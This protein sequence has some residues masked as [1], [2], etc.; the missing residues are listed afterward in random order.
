[1]PR[2]FLVKKPSVSPGK[3]NWSE[4]PDHE[5]GDI[6][7]PV[8][9]VF[10]LCT[11]ESEASPAES[12]PNFSQHHEHS[13]QTHIPARDPHVYVHMH[14]HTAELP[15]STAQG[16]EQSPN[17]EEQ[18]RTK[19]ST[20][21]RSKIK[22]TTGELPGNVSASSAPAAPGM[23]A[24]VCQVCQKTFQFQ[25]ML[26]RHLKC[27]NETK[28]HPCHFCGKGFN[29]TFDLK[30]H[31]RTHTGVR[32]Y[33]CGL[34][35][36]AFTQR[37]S[38]ESHMKKIHGVMQQY[39]YKERRSKLYVCEECGH[40]APTQETLLRHLHTQ[41][42]NSALLRSKGRKLTGAAAF[43]S[44]DRESL[45]SGSPHSQNC[46]DKCGGMPASEPVRLGR[47]RL[48]SH[49]PN[50]LFLQW[51]TELRDQAKERGLKT[52]HV[53]QKAINSLKKYPLPL[54]SGREAKIL[55]NFGDGIC[56]ILDQK[57]ERHYK[58]FG[59]N[60]V[61]ARKASAASPSH[62]LPGVDPLRRRSIKMATSKPLTDTSEDPSESGGGNSKNLQGDGGRDKGG[63]KRREY[64]PQK[65]TGG[66]AVLLALYRHCQISGN[67][68]FMFKMELQREAQP[69]CEKSFTVPD[70][71]SKYTAWSSVSTLI[72]KDLLIKTHSPARYSLTELGLALAE[73]LESSERG[74][75]DERGMSGPPTVDLT[76]DEKDED[77]REAWGCTARKQELVKELQRNGVTFDIRK[78]NVGD[79]LWVA[80][81]RVAPVQGQLRPP[82]G[83]ELVLDYIIERKRIDDL[84][85]SIIDGRFREQKFRLKRCGLQRPIYLVEECGSAAAHLS[86][87]ESTLQQAMVNTQVVDGFFVK[88]VQDVKESAAYLTV[89]TRQ[90]QKLYQNKTLFCRTREGEG[91]GEIMG[92]CSGREREKPS[93]CLISF[94]EFNQGACQTVR[95]VFARQ[96]MQ[97][98]GI[99]GD[100]AAAIL[101]HYSTVSSLLRAYEQCPTDTDR[102]KLLSS[103]RY[104]KLKRNVGPALSRTV[105]QLYWTPGP[106]S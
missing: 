32:P 8:A 5:R 10:P 44:T 70:L 81:E 59:E 77:E 39:A 94:T 106:L 91:E 21:V 87:P 40:T 71:G 3:R 48:L 26:N 80:R 88:R 14:M 34:C 30:R 11:E 86:L 46:P 42:P 9:M 63:K 51:L 102:E 74:S 61:E 47:K 13:T 103:I 35:D 45:S 99:S 43:V 75:E 52:Q 62:S 28:R 67:K 49:C 37:C 101:E 82:P 16:Q 53:Y 104:G 100:K 72:Q 56:K 12:S 69:L 17:P 58:E 18:E 19:E 57:L 92:E 7:I 31:V 95:E 2:A 97:I 27:H 85:G 60:R 93:C 64:V 33:K 96:L 41:H 22:V 78:L 36:K 66:Y 38:L 73:R 54:Q 76:E 79:F 15:S 50:P 84:C 89:M 90:L 83:K 25:R 29:D 55:Q 20:Y 105:Y 98:S 68:G 24:F 23:P 6:Y 65:G 4:V 1:M